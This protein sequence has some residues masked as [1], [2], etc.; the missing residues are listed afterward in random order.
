MSTTIRNEQGRNIPALVNTDG[1]G[2]AVRNMDFNASSEWVAE[3]T[4]STTDTVPTTSSDGVACAGASW[5]LVHFHNVQG[6][7]NWDWKVMV[8]NETADH[9]S[10]L[11][12]LSGTLVGDSGLTA[13][14]A[15]QRIDISGWD[16]AMV[17]VT[18]N[19]GTSVDLSVKV[20]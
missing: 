6:S 2:A 7:F 17:F 9:W 1:T 16:R 19:S 4:V 14:A 3:R 15:I 20:F 5:L 12:D 8:Y 11:Y 10:D 18:D 13:A